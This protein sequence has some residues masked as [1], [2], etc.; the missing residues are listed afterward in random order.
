MLAAFWVRP[1]YRRRRCRFVGAAV[2]PVQVP[3]GPDGRPGYR[4]KASSRPLHV[5][6]MGRDASRSDLAVYVGERSLL[7]TVCFPDNDGGLTPIEHARSAMDKTTTRGLVTVLAAPEPAVMAG[8]EGVVSELR[9]LRTGRHLTEWKFRHAGWMFGAGI[10]LHP[11]DDA[12]AVYAVAR[13]VLATWQ[14]LPESE[15][16]TGGGGR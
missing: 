14:W 2:Y 4:L 1:I 11:K 8:E 13:E 3:A 10:A 15:G 16:A 9:L 6:V 12:A 5:G 7:Q